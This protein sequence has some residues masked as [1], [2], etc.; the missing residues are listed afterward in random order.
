MICCFHIIKNRDRKRIE[1]TLSL[2]FQYLL[3]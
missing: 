3:R 2:I 1:I